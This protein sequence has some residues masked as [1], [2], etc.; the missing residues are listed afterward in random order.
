VPESDDDRVIAG[1]GREWKTFTHADGA[2]END[3]RG[4]F[5]SYFSNFPWNELPPAAVGADVGCGTGRWARFVAPRVGKLYCVDP[6]AAL[7]VARRALAGLPNCELIQARADAIPI[8]DHSLDFAYCLGVLHHVSNTEESLL[9]MARK[10]RPGAPLL[11]YL[12]YALE[13]RPT[14]Y[15][16]AWRMSDVVRRAVSPMPFAARRAL[17]TVIAALVYWPL[18][19]MARLFE[20][21]GAN[22]ERIPLATY[23]S[24]RFYFMRA[25]ALDRFGTRVEKRYTRAQI[26]EMM[27]RAG[28]GRI[29]FSSSAPFWVALGRK[30]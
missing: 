30:L 6:S 12:Y 7:D 24:K 5:H 29:E 21:L 17:S 23:R 13:N 1:F 14:W 11:L 20:I 4:A 19:R 10:L 15:R 2:A 9:A 22:P 16:L 8:P 18:A 27:T 26:A 28:L 3:L 25:D